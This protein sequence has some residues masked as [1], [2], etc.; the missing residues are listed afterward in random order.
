MKICVV[1]GIEKDTSE[2]SVQKRNTKSG[3]SIK[4]RSECKS[5]YNE[6]IR[7]YLKDNE[8]HKSRVK[9]GKEKRR[10]FIAQLKVSTGCYLCGYKKSSGALHYH[11]LDPSEKEFEIGWAVNKQLTEEKIMTEIKKCVLLCANCHSEVEQGVTKLELV[12]I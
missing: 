12:N 2:F 4:R 9:K 11:H 1:C 5:C 8:K 6:Y 10:E 3:I 7:K